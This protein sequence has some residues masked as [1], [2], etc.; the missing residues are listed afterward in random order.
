MSE[1][2]ETPPPDDEVDSR[3]LRERWAPL[4]LVFAG[5]FWNL[6]VSP[7]GSVIDE[8]LWQSYWM[9]I[10]VGTMW[11]QPAL[12][13]VWGA[14]GAQAWVWR[15]PA[16]VAVSIFLV[17]AMGGDGDVLGPLV[18]MLVMHL[19]FL[20]VLAVVRW[21]F[22]IRLGT[23]AHACLEGGQSTSYGMRYLFLWT[24][25]AALLAGMGKMM[26]FGAQ[27]WSQSLDGIA[28]WMFAFLVLLLPPVLLTGY[29]LRLERPRPLGVAIPFLSAP[30]TGLVAAAV[31]AQQ[32]MVRFFWE[33]MYIPFLLISLGALL[34]VV[35]AAA[36]LRWAGY[37]I[38]RSLPT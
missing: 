30:I 14:L 6:L 15:I 21:K 20:A 2:T 36:V 31:L 32:T 8:D 18:G 34:G 12:C 10:V 23:A 11:V 16:G 1:S 29:L 28:T 7:L 13:A 35:V 9:F 38:Y 5:G 22:R 25:V 17:L 24:S 3:K 27:D 4:G 33:E 19:M 37:R 26:A